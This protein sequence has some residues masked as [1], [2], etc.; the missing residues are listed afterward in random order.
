[1]LKALAVAGCLLLPGGIASA[2]TPDESMPPAAKGMHLTFSETFN[3]PLSWC[4]EFCNDQRWRT[5]Y[6]HSGIT[7]LSR[8]LSMSGSESEVY[9]DPLYLGLGVNPFQVN[10][11]LTI[12]TEP[13]S[14]RVKNAVYAAWPDWWEQEGRKR[15][16]PKFTSGALTTER[17][18][19]QLY[20]YFE[21]RIKVSNVVGAWPAFWL[22]E[23]HGDEID[24]TEVLGGRPTRHEMS[25]HRYTEPGHQW[26]SLGIK[27]NTDDLS[28]DFHTYAVLWTPDAVVSYLDD[29]EVGRLE[30][31]GL[32]RPLYFIINMAMDGDWNKKDGFVAAPDAHTKLMVQYIKAYH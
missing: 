32:H 23:D 24:I 5:K 16:Y 21:A 14:E 2:Q 11:G 3:A 1:M 25:I 17:S 22:Y 31:F 9:M 20:G 4:S 29:K 13:A 26:H 6:S 19:S 10:H 12:L 28:Q 8:G 7:P 18:F 27:Y 30:N 15:V